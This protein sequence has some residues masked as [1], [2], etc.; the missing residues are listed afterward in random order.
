VISQDEIVSRIEGGIEGA[1]ATVKDIGGGNHWSAVVVAAAFEGKS[2]VQR[3]QMVYA[4][5]RDRMLPH[6]ES[7]HALQ[8]KT[9]TPA[10]AEG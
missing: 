1:K 4:T 8:L 6:D 3:H 2:L 9:M 5:V 10:E 7:I